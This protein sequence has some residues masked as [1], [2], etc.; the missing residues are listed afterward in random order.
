MVMKNIMMMGTQ[1]RILM[2]VVEEINI[3]RCCPFVVGVA[4]DGVDIDVGEFE[5][6]ML[7]LLGWRLRMM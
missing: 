3:E 1:R 2:M 4:V 7:L 5:W 6:R